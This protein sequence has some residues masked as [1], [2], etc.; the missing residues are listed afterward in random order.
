MYVNIKTE[1]LRND[2]RYDTFCEIERLKKA[3]RK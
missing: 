3:M 1:Q 2:C